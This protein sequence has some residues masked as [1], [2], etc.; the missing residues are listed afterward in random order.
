MEQRSALVVFG[1]KLP[2]R[3]TQTR[4]RYDTVVA[5]ETLRNEIEA[6]GE[7]WIDLDGL[8]GAGSIYEASVMLE[9]LSRLTFPDGTRVAKACVYEG[10]ELWWM[11]YN[12]LFRFYCLPYTQHRKLLEYLREFRRV[13]FYRP[14]YQNLFLHYLRAH[15]CETELLPEP[16][17]T[18][19]SLLPFGV[20][21]QIALTLLFLPIL[22]IRRHHLMVFIG[23]KFEKGKDYDFRLKFIYQELRQKSIVFVEFV[24]SLE[25]WKTI[26]QHAFIRRRPVIYSEAIAF[27]GR[28]ASFI[29]GGRRRGLREFGPHLFRSVTDPDARFRFLIATQYLHTVYDDIWAIRIMARLLRAIGIRTAIIEV[30]SER[31][32]HSVLGCKMDAIPTVGILHGVV[33]RQYIPHDFMPCFDG[34][35]SMSIDRYGV[36]S[37]WW[38]EYYEKNGKAYRP[39]Q[40]FVSGPMRPLEAG[41]EPELGTTSGGEDLLK[42]LFISEQMGYSPEVVP[43]L[44]KL[45]ETKDIDLYVKFR[46]YR[47][48]FETWITNHEP[49]LLRNVKILRGSVSEAVAQCDVVVG[50]HS[51]AALEALLKLKPPIFYATEKWGDY[52]NLEGYDYT[53][54]LFAKTPEDL[55]ACLMKSRQIPLETLKELRER[56]FGDPYRNGS[57]WVVD[58]A[59][60]LLKNAEKSRGF[61]GR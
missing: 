36:W 2:R 17:L 51:T 9:E 52:F 55:V 10:Y 44:K 39:E 5:H 26:I 7:E 30:A 61:F 49:E 25:S 35:K 11:N 58:Q 42:V 13:H 28:F 12:S 20:A 34:E 24:R 3:W 43:Y 22:V 56:F 16:E 8:I 59:E 31:T 27:V 53:Y 57:A 45:V 15:G 37:E 19:P 32:F 14:P 46:P 1:N 29:T 38:K 60:Q 41:S 21:I 6:R 40:L 23:D 48:G 33:S 50:S 4:H 18:S 54:R 47:D